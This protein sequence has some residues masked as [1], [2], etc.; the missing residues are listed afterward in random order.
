MD[1]EQSRF[2]CQI[3]GEQDGE[4]IIVLELSAKTGF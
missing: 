3:G 2:I 1:P 4:E